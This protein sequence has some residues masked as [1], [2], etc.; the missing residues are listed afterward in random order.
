MLD[1]KLIPSQLLARNDVNKTIEGITEKDNSG[2]TGYSRDS[3]TSSRRRCV[4][5]LFD[6]S[7]QAREGEE[8]DDGLEQEDDR[9][10]PQHHHRCCGTLTPHHLASRT[11]NAAE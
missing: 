11:V 7:G 3:A 5:K 4:V 9:D 10:A 2:D 8:D 6:V 1:A